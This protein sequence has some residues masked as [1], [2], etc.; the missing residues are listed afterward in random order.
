M[1]KS[2]CDSERF[3]P[4]DKLALSRFH[5]YISNLLHPHTCK[6]LLIELGFFHLLLFVSETRLHRFFFNF[7]EPTEKKVSNIFFFLRIIFLFMLEDYYFAL[8]DKIK[9]RKLTLSH[10]EFKKIDHL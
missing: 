6:K 10:P 8:L 3:S 2:H 5:V 7:Y 9:L 1:I 4:A